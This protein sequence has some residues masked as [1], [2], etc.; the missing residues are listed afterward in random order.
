VREG[1]RT[2]LLEVMLEELAAQGYSEGTLAAVLSRAGVSEKEYFAEYPDFDAGL[3]AA[4]ERIGE[5][6]RAV[7]VGGCE[8]GASWPQRVREGLWGVLEAIAAKPE[9]AEVATRRFP[10]I[11]AAAY[12][13]YG[14]LISSFVPFLREGRELAEDGEQLPEDVELLA[15][16]AAEALIFV[17]LE[18]GRAERLPT[19][20]PEIL[21][22]IL[23][24]FLGPE[25][26]VAEM[27]AAA[28]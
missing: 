15:L 25:R 8:A 3:F 14:A 20:G 27:R 2:R 9:I 23:V 12:E 21:F 10:A 6:V 17:E 28:A 16:G 26:A 11:G 1:Q 24:P 22:S 7:A 4:Y 18:A 19:M 5:R 13:R